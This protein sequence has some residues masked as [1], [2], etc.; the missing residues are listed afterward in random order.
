MAELRLPIQPRAFGAELLRGLGCSTNIPCPFF[1]EGVYLCRLILRLG[2]T[3]NIK[4]LAE[5]GQLLMLYTWFSCFLYIA[6]VRKL[7]RLKDQI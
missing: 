5:I 3:T 6:S 4:F 2:V 7:E 1:W